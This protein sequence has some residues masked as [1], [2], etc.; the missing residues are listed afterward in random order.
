MKK[1]LLWLLALIIA[2]LL[3]LVS[4]LAYLFHDHDGMEANQSGGSFL[5]SVS[6]SIAP[7]MGQGTTGTDALV[8]KTSQIIAHTNRKEADKGK[9]KPEVNERLVEKPV[10]NAKE[11]EP[12]EARNEPGD[13]KTAS[14]AVPLPASDSSRVKEPVPAIPANPTTAQGRLAALPRIAPRVKKTEPKQPLKASRT[15]RADKSAKPRQE[16]GQKTAGKHQQTTKGDGGK[17]TARGSAGQTNKAQGA[18]SKGEKAG[19]VTVLRRKIERNKR[20]PRAARMSRKAGVGRIRVTIDRK[21][22]VL[23][24]ALIHP[25]GVPSLD[26]ELRRVAHRASPFPPIPA[27]LKGRSL[28]FTA[29][30]RFRPAF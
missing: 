11:E 26:Q 12:V 19:Y 28:A 8:A 24:V 27:R 22:Q 23:K 21:G 17:N 25:T 15:F 13:N 9:L 1:I 7:D 3:H 20:Y 2:L 29:T 16:R 4:A 14:P 10:Q 18:A 6:I 5:S 30:L